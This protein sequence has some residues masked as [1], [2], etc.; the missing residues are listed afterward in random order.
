MR[1]IAQQGGRPGASFGDA[2]P[3][4]LRMR[5]PRAAAA[6]LTAGGPGN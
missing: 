6:T 2:A 5:K 4:E 1:R 3:R